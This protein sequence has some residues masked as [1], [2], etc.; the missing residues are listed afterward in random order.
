[1]LKKL[2]AVYRSYFPK[3]IPNY[4]KYIGAL[5]QLKGLEIGGPSPA[6]D[7]KGYLPLYATIATLD[8]CNFG[9][10][11]V[12]EGKLKEGINFRYGKH[13]GYQYISDGSDMSMI[14]DNSYEFV[15]SCH[16]LEHF[17]NPIKALKEWSRILKAEGYMVLVVPHKDQTFDHRRPLTTLDHLI[18]D[19]KNNTQ[20]DDDTHFEEVNTLHDIAKDWGIDSSE[21]LRARTANNI[22]NRCVH[23]HVFNTPLMVQLSDYMG[24]QILDVSHFNPFN[25]ILLLQK[26]ENGQADNSAYLDPHHLIYQKSSFPSDKIW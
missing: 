9:T 1:M 2:E 15:L 17:A 16:S 11:T 26:T 6:F 5:F 21:A 14:R 25:I 12:W 18:A 3:R 8:G 24:F 4:K 10:E 13:R 22:N 23:H 7:K 19:E 20:E